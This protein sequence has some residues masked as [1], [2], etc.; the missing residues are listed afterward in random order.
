[1]SQED[2][3]GASVF[4]L[5]ESD[6]STYPNGLGVLVNLLPKLEV[7]AIV[8][9]NHVLPLQNDGGEALHAAVFEFELQ[10][11]MKSHVRLKKK[12]VEHT[13]VIP[14]NAL[15]KHK[16]SANVLMF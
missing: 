5:R 10:A 3:F 2:T 6:Q 13:K 8:F 14:D 9:S 1:M 7:K 11:G 12:D 15:S 16:C 4:T